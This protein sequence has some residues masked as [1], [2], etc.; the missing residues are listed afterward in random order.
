M[1]IA[2]LP[3]KRLEGSHGVG[4]TGEMWL[5]WLASAY[6]FTLPEGGFQDAIAYET[7]LRIFELRTQLARAL[8]MEV[9]GASADAAQWLESWWPQEK[10][11]PQSVSALGADADAASPVIA[12]VVAAY[13]SAVQWKLQAAAAGTGTP[14]H[15][16]LENGSAWWVA[17]AEHRLKWAEHREYGKQQ[18][19]ALNTNVKEAIAARDTARELVVK[20]ME[21]GLRALQSGNIDV[22]ERCVQICKDLGPLTT[23][24]WISSA[25]KKHRSCNIE[26]AIRVVT[27][28]ILFADHSMRALVAGQDGKT[29]IAAA[30]EAAASARDKALVRS[31]EYDITLRC[32]CEEVVKRADALAERAHLLES[33][34]TV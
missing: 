28:I 14:L 26:P 13:R 32:G 12:N 1:I 18:G 33:G 21:A 15:M 7:Q 4:V 23:Q 24:D 10:R 25:M 16:H 17:L 27:Q 29:D 31:S 8:E 2:E 30:W 5:E 3:L 19:L 22:H 34:Q 20:P 6:K 9:M 11:G